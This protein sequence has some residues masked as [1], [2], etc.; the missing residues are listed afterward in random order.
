MSSFL[1]SQ[2][3]DDSQAQSKA[4]LQK[5]LLNKT[6]YPYHQIAFDL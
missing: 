3:Q 4:S 5:H 1:S 6:Q 2:N